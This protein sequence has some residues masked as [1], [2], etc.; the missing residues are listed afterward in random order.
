MSARVRAQAMRFDGVAGQ[1]PRL[2]RD[3]VEHDRAFQSL[4]VER[5]EPLPRPP[6]SNRPSRPPRCRTRPRKSRDVRC[7]GRCARRGSRGA[8]LPYRRRRGRRQGGSGRRAPRRWTRGQD[9]AELVPVAARLV[10]PLP[11]HAAR[12]GPPGR[13]GQRSRRDVARAASSKNVFTSFSLSSHSIN[14]RCCSR[15]T[16]CA[17]TPLISRVSGSTSNHPA[18]AYGM[19]PAPGTRRPPA[20]GGSCARAQSWITR[21][22]TRTLTRRRALSRRLEPSRQVS[23]RVIG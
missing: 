10:D 3:L 2:L 20:A 6:R 21:A 11:P 8:S 23:R 4:V 17:C 9:G 7:R 5:P 18:T 13:G 12:E 15:V 22:D 16:D 19:S 14:A 1:H